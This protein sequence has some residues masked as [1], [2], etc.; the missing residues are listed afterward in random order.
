MKFINYIIPLLIIIGL[1]SVLATSQ[2]F[3]LD[4]GDSVTV[5]NKVITLINVGEG[6][7]IVIDVDGVLDVISP[8]S[9]KEVNGLI[10]TVID[11]FYTNEI[12]E[13]SAI[14]EVSFGKDKDYQTATI[15]AKPHIIRR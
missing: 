1:T 2:Q 3:F 9:T 10:I 8:L 7:A 6:G 11:T 4:T 13:R 15:S 14:I 12:S 5:N